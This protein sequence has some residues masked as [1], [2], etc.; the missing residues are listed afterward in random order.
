MR[1]LLLASAAVLAL[2]GSVLADPPQITASDK[3]CVIVQLT[4][5]SAYGAGNVIGS[6]TAAGGS[7]LLTIPGLT[8]V[9]PAT[10]NSETAVM[11][12]MEL[13]FQET[14][15]EEFDVTTF[16]TAPA[17][18]FTDK[19]PAA[20]SG[21]DALNAQFPIKLNNGISLLGSNGTTYAFDGIG[22]IIKMID[23][24][25]RFVITTPGTPT[26]TAA[27]AKLCVGVLQ[28]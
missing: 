18:T 12:S 28:D 22:R 20:I 25:G 8:R 24:I 11:H 23:G 6:P 9:S 7:G 3:K 2:G 27:T 15:T 26:F 14:H 17:T 4:T 10:V 5:G 19:S 16:D 1:R 21:A 13:K